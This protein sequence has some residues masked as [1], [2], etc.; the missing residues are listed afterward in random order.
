MAVVTE[1]LKLRRAIWNKDLRKSVL[2]KALTHY[3][4]F[5]EDKLVSNI[6]N[7][8]PAGRVY[9]VG[10]LT[11]RRT[12][13]NK[14]LRR[15]K[16]FKT[17]VVTGGIF[18]TASAKG[19]PPAKLTSKLRNSIRVR[20]IVGELAVMASVNANGAAILDDPDKLDRPFF[21]ETIR[22]SFKED[23]APQMRTFLREL[24]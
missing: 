8:T 9:R 11:E 16:K 4:G 20:R 21:K 5:L 22:T 2:N 13:K 19:Q 3:A 7:S 10:S 14:D 24:L 1:T 15:S 17:K 12:A 18:H 6:D 23:M